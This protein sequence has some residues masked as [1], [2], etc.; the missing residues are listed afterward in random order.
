MRMEI[1]PNLED[2]ADQWGDY[3]WNGSLPSAQYVKKVGGIV[4]GTPWSPPVEYKT[5]GTAQG[6]NA[7]DQGYQKGKLS[8]D[9][10]EKFFPWLNSYLA[11]M[12][13]NGVDVD[14][15]SIQNEP[16]WW[17]SY[18][19]CLY[20]PQD[21]VNLVKNYAYLCR[22]TQRVHA[23]WLHRIY[24]LVHARPLGLCRNG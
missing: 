13:K 12:K 20:D 1:S 3:D 21:L 4:F 2:K 24:L 15:V 14:A 10:Y 8:E 17:V 11:W 19:G 6:G 22:R 9:C 5:N 18:S 16:D 7:E 23:G